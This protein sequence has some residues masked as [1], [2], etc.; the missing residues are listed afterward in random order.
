MST[1]NKNVI[2]FTAR[3]VIRP[4]KIGGSLGA[5]EALRVLIID[6]SPEDRMVVRLALESH[7]LLLTEVDTGERGLASVKVLLP[8][9]I[10]LD[11]HLP[12]LDGF[13]MLDALRLP[14]G[15]MPCA[16]IMLT[17]TSDAET[18]TRLLKAGALDFLNKS[19]I[20]EDYLQRSVLGAVA[21]FRLIAEHWE[22]QARNAHLAAIVAS[23]AD[24]IFSA[25]LDDRILSWN[26]GAAALFGYAEEEAIGRTV[27]ELIV[28]E[29]LSA[30]RRELYQ[31]VRTGGAAI[32]LETVR[33]RKDGGLVPVDVNASPIF[34]T[35]GAV[36]AV[37]LVARDISERKRAEL[38][39]AMSTA[40]IKSTDDAVVSFDADGRFTSWNPAAELLFRI[41]VARGHRPRR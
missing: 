35:S 17:G 1:V 16:V 23:S 32:A 26:P 31:N 13:E 33:R 9:C 30:E 19:Q 12:D 37:S 14:N 8:D 7:R 39:L 20:Q 34:D 36:I 38:A 18:A 6:D 2:A 22:A 10:L 4:R 11:Y 28:P 29:N 40:I 27:E 24:A 21:R 41:L 3:P 5:N 25:G 15:T